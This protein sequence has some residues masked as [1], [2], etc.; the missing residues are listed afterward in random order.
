MSTLSLW[1]K[2]LLFFALGGIVVFAGRTGS[3]PSFG[4][5]P[6]R[7]GGGIVR[8]SETTGPSGHRSIGVESGAVGRGENLVPFSDL[9]KWDFSADCPSSAPALIL[10]LHG[11]DLTLLGFMFPLAEGEAIKA[12]CLMSTTQTCCY[13]PKPQFNQFVLVETP[14]PIAF[15]R[16]R[17]VRVKGRFFVEPRP[18]DGY[19]YRLEATSVLPAA[20]Q[21]FAL[22]SA[23]VG[24]PA[25]HWS[26]MDE[27]RPTQRPKSV[28]ELVAAMHIPAAIASLSDTKIT[29]TAYIAGNVMLPVSGSCL[30]LARDFWDGCCVGV[31]PSPF[32]AIPAQL[33][34]DSPQPEPW[35]QQAVFQ[36]RLRIRERKD[37]GV[38]GMIF[39]ADA[40]L[41][42]P[43]S[44][45]NEEA[46]R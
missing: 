32:N 3:P 22:A 28:Q 14:V 46:L 24:T 31:P 37:W 39:L 12:F 6:A 18:L 36:G 27:L 7:S 13:G 44:S 19:I 17:P 34:T 33:A 38:E 41:I 30:L 8:V 35:L 29:V 43:A 45:P 11:Q 25:F 1:R 21:V 23:A 26:W 16:L 20:D 9:A 40:R 10:S 42:G 2:A 15:E 5:D 4:G